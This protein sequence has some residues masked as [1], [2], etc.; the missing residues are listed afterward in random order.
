M[1]P[2]ERVGSRVTYDLDE[3]CIQCPRQIFIRKH[4]LLEFPSI[5]LPVQALLPCIKAIFHSRYLKFFYVSTVANMKL[6]D[7]EEGSGEGVDNKR[8]NKNRENENNRRER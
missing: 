2:R 7:I 5:L 8:K 4:T 1:T 6:K 3:N